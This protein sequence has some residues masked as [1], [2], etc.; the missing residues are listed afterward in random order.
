MLELHSTE[1]LI[2]GVEYRK[3]PGFPYYLVGT[4]GSVMSCLIC[5][6]RPLTQGPWWPL[7]GNPDQK[8]YLTATLYHH[9][10][11]SRLYIH[12]LVATLFHGEC[13]EGCETRH[14]DG[15]LLNNDIGNLRWGTRLENAQDR[16]RHGTTSLGS[17]HASAKLTEKVVFEVRRAI[18]AGER[19]RD[20]ADR[21]GL[22][23]N[24]VNRIHTQP[25]Y[26]RHVTLPGQSEPAPRRTRSIPSTDEGKRARRIADRL[27]EMRIARGWSQQEL[28][29]RVGVAKITIGGW[30]CERKQPSVENI[31]KLCDALGVDV[32]AFDKE[33]SEWVSGSVWR[34]PSRKKST[35]VED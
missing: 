21:L 4:D 29:R 22:T 7:Q 15:N 24:I 10:R 34:R 1:G 13:P 33:P 30:E 20:I 27:R 3:V 8:G 11:R 9:G 14:L 32:A 19:Q 28:G 26:W 25:G 23:F 18:A 17:R 31:Q 35:V 6:K 16:V 12:V 5:G 2:E